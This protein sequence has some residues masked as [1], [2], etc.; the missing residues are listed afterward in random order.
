[1]NRRVAMGLLAIGAVMLMAAPAQAGAAGARGAKRTVSIK[2]F[3]DTTG[4]DVYVVGIGEKQAQSLPQPVSVKL[5]NQNG[6]VYI[7]PGKSKTILVPGGKGALVAFF[8]DD[9]VKGGVLP[10]EPA[11][12]ALYNLSP[13]S[14]TTAG[15]FEIEDGPIELG[16]SIPRVNIMK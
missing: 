10:P 3:N 1:M 12:E 4:T 2:V 6:G 8:A 14:K 5:A 13:G 16:I 9:V 11:A 15:V 7:A